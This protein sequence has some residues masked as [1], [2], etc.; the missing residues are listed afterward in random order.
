MPQL[1]EVIEKPKFKKFRPWD[2][3][4]DGTLSISPNDTS[5][6]KEK[7]V[8]ESETR[9]DQEV[10]KDITRGKQEVNKRAIKGKS[11]VIERVTR[12][13]QEINQ[14]VEQGV[15][16]D[17]LKTKLFGLVGHQKKIFNYVLNLCNTKRD[18]T[19]GLIVTKQMAIENSMSYYAAKDALKA[20][21]KKNLINRL[22]G[23]GC[24]GGFIHL[25]IPHIVKKVSLLLFEREVNKGMTRGEQELNQE[26]Q[27]GV[28]GISSSSSNLLNTTT[29][30]TRNKFLLSE[31]WQNVSI[32]PLHEIGFSETH[33]AQIAKQ[34]ILSPN[35]VQ[36]SIYAFSFD[37]KEN[38][39]KKEITG[40][41]INFFMGILRKG[42]PYTPPDGYETP[43]ERH[44][45]LYEEKM[46]KLKAQREEIEKKAFN[47]AFEDWFRDLPDS[48]KIE[49]IPKNFRNNPR[50]EKNKIL[51]GGARDYFTKEI[52]PD[53]KGKIESG[54]DK[55]ALPEV[56]Q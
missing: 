21:I 53:I 46:S 19:T 44:M 27:R 36:D 2:L 20:L 3:N 31:E 43:Q 5:N 50:L 14:E 1:N 18:T 54:A 48:K 39:K 30:D 52:W 35:V 38:N 17:K 12:G 49:F 29:T 47:L 9:G 51:E 23:K 4:G 13:D 6:K 22:Q 26:V 55:K 33:L 37:L 28:L 40:N 45:R 15:D 25:D 41:P 32:K 11:E 10:I 42:L 16:I 56:N 34:N 24:R 7:E 8:F